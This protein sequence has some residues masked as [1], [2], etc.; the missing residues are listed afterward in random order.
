MLGLGLLL[1]IAL[2]A[3][4]V[5]TAPSATHVA[6]ERTVGDVTELVEIPVERVARPRSTEEVQ[7]L[8]VSHDG[9]VSIGGGRFSMGGQI[10]TDDTLFLDLRE[11]ND[12]LAYDKDARTIR[13]EAGA[14]WRHIQE[15]VD[16]DDL[17]VQIMQSYANFTVGGSASVNAHGRYVNRG[18]VVHSVR[19]LELVLADGSRLHTSRTEHPEIFFGAIGGY[20]ALGVITE[21]EL[22]LDPNE[23]LERVVERMPSTD[24]GAWF[25]D[26]IRGSEDAVMFNAD[27]Y[28]P[29]FDDLVAITYNRTDRDVTVE[30]RLQPGGESSSVDKLLY[31][32]VSEAPLGREARSEVLD[33][34]RLTG[35]PV[36]WRNHEASYDVAGLDP[37]SRARNTYVLQEYFLPVDRFDSFVPRMAEIFQRYDVNVVNVSIRHASAD[38]DTWLS[39]APEE[40][41]AFVVYHK[42]GTDEAAWTETGI[43][44]R[45]MIDAVLDE[46]GTYYLPYQLHLTT[47]QFLRGYPRAPGFFEIKQRLDPTYTFR[48]RLWDQ[49]F[50][51][52]RAQSDA[53]IEDA[54]RAKLANRE[55]WL[56]PEDQTFLTVPEWYIVYSADELG[57]HLQTQPPSTFPFFESIQ[58]F[59]TIYASVSNAVE[60]RWPHNSG[61]HTMIW[62]I[63]TSYAVEYAAKGLYEGSIGR[64][65]EWWSG[66]GWRTNPKD[67]AYAEVATEYG[68]FIHHT[69]W[70]A[71][72]FAEGRTRVGAAS[73]EGSVR[74]IER[75]FALWVELAA[76]SVWGSL[77]GSASAATYGAETGVIQA[78]VKPGAAD[79]TAID[80]IELVDDLGDGHQL[81]SMPRYEPFTQA[82]V[83]LATS[84]AEFVEIAGGT[85]IV[86]Q[87]VAPQDWTQAPLWGDVVTAWPILTEPGTQ[88]IALEVATKRLDDVLPAI[89]QAGA[90][91]E[92]VYDY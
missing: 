67:R 79:P 13:V 14:T 44:T 58:Q 37:G 88:R 80:G 62:V 39:W 12:V 75:G 85:T 26:H 90:R 21:V 10:G 54:I 60:G 71:F 29:A 19:A 34:L 2:A 24:F 25:E 42:M 83:D 86:V 31:W 49:H 78:W 20:G 3:L 70:Y 91:I 35:N 50:P 48:N 30:D 41:F 84:G 22:N 53:E 66:D 77:M 51:A 23:K 63:G 18:P 81:I 64:L 27:I 8:L 87:V 72:P 40:R 7:A 92:H 46:G 61:Y 38:P 89:E 11:M 69:P 5:A 17:S 74:G 28:P 55:G 82:V 9:P 76:K 4:V 6:P 52:V 65:S 15:H 1:G 45:E 68:A 73:G 56:R 33:R 57:H 16:P 36:V 59:R 32:Y 47:E 43:W